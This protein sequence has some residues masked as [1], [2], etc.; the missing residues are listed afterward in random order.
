M[1]P[2]QT[3]QV[4]QLNN[5]YSVLQKCLDQW[6]NF[7]SVFAKNTV[8]IGRLSFQAFSH[9]TH[10]EQLVPTLIVDIHHL[11]KPLRRC[12][13]SLL[14]YGATRL[15]EYIPCCVL[16]TAILKNDSTAEKRREEETFAL[17]SIALYCFVETNLN[18]GVCVEGLSA[19]LLFLALYTQ[20]PHPTL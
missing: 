4:P 12:F 5:C 8:S 6:F 2:A 14:S 18:C 3:T 17:A 13:F 9:P 19:C 10:P 1:L 11:S 16:R 20:H 7:V 15:C